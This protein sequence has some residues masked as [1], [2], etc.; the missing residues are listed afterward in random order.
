MNTE[1]QEKIDAYVALYDA[2]SVKTGTESIS[3]VIFQEVIK[4]MRMKY[5][6][7]AMENGTGIHW[8]P[9]NR[10]STFARSGNPLTSL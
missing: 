2:I 1:T 10:R 5:I 9:K 6:A 7:R 8:Q 3:L 4:D